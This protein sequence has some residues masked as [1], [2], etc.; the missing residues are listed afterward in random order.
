MEYKD[1]LLEA[2]GNRGARPVLPDGVDEWARFRVVILGDVGPKDLN[3][4]RL[5]A[6]EQ[7][8]QVRGGTLIL[9]AGDEMMPAAFAGTPLERMLPV[10]ESG[11]SR[12]GPKV[13]ACS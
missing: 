8:V 7:F 4:D 2:E 11:T 12:V 1:I 3:A 9:I 6:L 13:T 10:E 5:N